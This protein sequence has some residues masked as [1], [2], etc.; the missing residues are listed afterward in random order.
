[1][2]FLFCLQ[3]KQIDFKDMSVNYTGVLGELVDLYSSKRLCIAACD[4]PICHFVQFKSDKGRS[5]WKAKVI[6]NHII[7]KCQY[8][9]IDLLYQRP[10]IPNLLARGVCKSG[11]TSVYFV[12]VRD[13][14]QCD[15]SV[16]CSWNVTPTKRKGLLYIDQAFATDIQ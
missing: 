12:L 13:G 3:F 10:A 16:Y 2:A 6:L 15:F 5:D 14:F 9:S 11:C 8:E 4:R 7:A 1:M